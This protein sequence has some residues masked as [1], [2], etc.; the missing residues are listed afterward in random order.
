MLNKYLSHTP[1][2]KIC[3][4]A[5]SIEK[6]FETGC[7][8]AF[9]LKSYKVVIVN[10]EIK[11]K[12]S[13]LSFINT[14]C[15]C[16]CFLWMELQLGFRGRHLH[17]AISLTIKVYSLK[18]LFFGMCRRTTFGAVPQDLSIFVEMISLAWNLPNRL[19][20]P[21]SCRASPC[22]NYK[23]A[24]LGCSFLHEFWGGVLNSYSFGKPSSNLP[25]PHAFYPLHFSIFK[26]LGIY[27]QDRE[28]VLED[29]ICRKPDIAQ[30]KCQIHVHTPKNK[31][32]FFPKI[33]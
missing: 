14:V 21:I 23:H 26:I 32:T 2:P 17:L 28:P 11:P 25:S 8:I 9:K 33:K 1:C 13:N 31:T 3:V 18:F 19:D 22:R 7:L 24:L 5:H 6:R 27:E 20:Q 12:Q 10:L 30:R 16:V 29:L 15:V 4:L